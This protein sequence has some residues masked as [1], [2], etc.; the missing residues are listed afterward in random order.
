MPDISLLGIHV[1]DTLRYDKLS[2][3]IRVKNNGTEPMELSFKKQKK[4]TDPQFDTVPLSDMAGDKKNRLVLNDKDHRQRCELLLMGIYPS[5]IHLEGKG[6]IVR[7]FIGDCPGLPDVAPRSD[8][9]HAQQAIRAFF[10]NNTLY[11]YDLS[12]ADSIPVK[13]DP[14]VPIRFQNLYITD[15][16]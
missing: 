4:L 5:A 10:T 13:V 7:A 15:L 2:Y 12:L 9:L 14:S 11:C 1:E 16:Q 8:S 6:S 3:V